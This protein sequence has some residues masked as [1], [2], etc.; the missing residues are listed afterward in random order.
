L[1]HPCHPAV[2]ATDKISHPHA[3]LSL[4]LAIFHSVGTKL[5]KPRKK[6]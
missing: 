2:A 4:F 6:N 3:E 1:T 5:K